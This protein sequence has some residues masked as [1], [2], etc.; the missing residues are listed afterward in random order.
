MTTRQTVVKMIPAPFSRCNQVQ[1]LAL[2]G[3]INN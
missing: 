2:A 3:F 1:H